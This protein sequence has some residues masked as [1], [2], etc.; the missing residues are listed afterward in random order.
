[1][2]N[3]PV[4]IEKFLCYHK[5]MK[6]LQEWPVIGQKKAVQFLQAAL[7][8]KKIAPVYIFFGP[9]H[10][11]KKTIAYYFVKTLLC[12]KKERIFCD[13]CSA[14]QSFE[15]GIYPD[16]YRLRSEEGK[17]NI[18][19]EQVRE[20][21]RKI[22]N[23]SFLGNYKI[24]LVERAEELS[25]EAANSLLKTL[26]EPPRKT[27]FIFLTQYL[28]SIPL[29]IVSR[30]QVVNFNLVPLEEILNYLLNKNLKEDLAWEIAYLSQ[31]RPG[32]AFD[33]LE[34]NSLFCKRKEEIINFL[35]LLNLP[36]AKKFDYIEEKISAKK[37]LKDK[38]A[39]AINL[40]D[41]WTTIFRSLLL[42]KSAF[43]E[44]KKEIFI[45][46]TINILSQKYS[47]K[48]LIKFI[49]KINQGKKYIK[50]N[51]NPRLVLENLILNF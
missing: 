50:N 13:Y 16:F 33:Y 1:M 43:E 24:V 35:N 5:N 21:N 28:K 44:N 26:E 9:E 10:L 46:E 8:S 34:N 2:S 27:L 18:S 40:L 39:T 32:L 11:G 45:T 38:C 22:Q 6:K 3:F 17:K 36:L 7:L 19:I 47:Y 41:D 20:I 30:S 25:Q 29:T 4:A 15:A 51:I 31:G 42:T 37:T 23:S 48:D 14:C 49:D 12:L